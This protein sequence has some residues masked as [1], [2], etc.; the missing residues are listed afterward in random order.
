MSALEKKTLLGEKVAPWK[1]KVSHEVLMF[2]SK[3]KEGNSWKDTAET[4]VS[5]Q[6]RINKCTIHL[7]NKLYFTEATEEGTGRN[8]KL[9]KPF[10]H[11][12]F[13]AVNGP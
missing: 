7:A 6:W 5:K 10:C 2:N 11:R 13:L 12:G 3:E 1:L 9:S 4:R 8:K